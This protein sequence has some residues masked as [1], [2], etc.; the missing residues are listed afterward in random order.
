MQH[1]GTKI[2]DSM[3]GLPIS[4]LGIGGSALNTQWKIG[5]IESE[6]LECKSVHP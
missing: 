5:P 4:K 2:E 1:D 6:H 3:R